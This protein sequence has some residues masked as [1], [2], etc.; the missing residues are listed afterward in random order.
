MGFAAAAAAIGKFTAAYGGYIAAASTAVS[1]AT[2]YRT[3]QNQR[4]AQEAYNEQLEKE[5]I[6]QYQELDAVEADVIYESHAE[7]LEAQRQLMVARSTINLQAAV[8][9]TYGNS[10][11]TAIQDLNTGFGQRMSEITVRRDVQLDHITRTAED[12]QAG[13]AQASDL[14][15]Q[16][17]AFY[18][19]ISAGLGTFSRT[20]A[21]TSELGRAFRSSQP[22]T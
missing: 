14:N 11:A 7:S 3:S 22:A 6:R 18:T 2:A 1:A 19:A 21:A 15:L 10:V 12:I 9:G 16:Q 20:K 5:A 17:P 13:T 4:A 8:T